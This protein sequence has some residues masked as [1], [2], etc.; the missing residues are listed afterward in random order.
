[1]R[2]RTTAIALCCLVVSGCTRY[3]LQVQP[4][5]LAPTTSG[6]VSAIVPR[7]DV[8]TSVFLEAKPSAAQNVVDA[9][10]SYWATDLVM[11]KKENITISTSLVLAGAPNPTQF[12]IYS[13]S[14]DGRNCTLDFNTSYVL[15]PQLRP[16]DAHDGLKGQYNYDVASSERLSK[17][18][19]DGVKLA[20]ILAPGAGAPVVAVAGQVLNS[21]L[22]DDIRGDVNAGYSQSI[23]IK[24]P[25]VDLLAIN[26]SY[27]TAQ[28]IVLPFEITAGKIEDNNVTATYKLA[29]LKIF[30]E[31]KTT[32]VGKENPAGL[33]IY[34]DSVTTRSAQIIVLDTSGA[35]TS[36]RLTNVYQEL[37]S[38]AA[39][40]PLASN[41]ENLGRS[42]EPASVVANYCQSARAKLQSL[43]FNKF[44]GAAY[45]WALYSLSP[46]HVAGGHDDFANDKSDCLSTG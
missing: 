38:G 5:A 7:S 41:I 45:L 32:F 22:A 44:D 39:G 1:M 40:V 33:P 3:L 8:Y 28:A 4:S 11:Q 27:P 17:Y 35:G 10:K 19:N 25:L 2:T 21:S 14:H 16:T 31:R 37:N 15:T 6:S 36:S 23:D 24:V 9:C 18:L 26:N 29:D 20:S 43:G 30:V 13:V 12:P 34:I 46:Y 42:G